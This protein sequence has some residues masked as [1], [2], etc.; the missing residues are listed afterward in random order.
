MSV[1]ATVTVPEKGCPPEIQKAA[2][3]G[4]QR[5]RIC[6]G[7]PEMAHNESIAAEASN[8]AADININDAYAPRYK[9]YGQ[10]IISSRE[11][12]ENFT[13]SGAAIEI[14][15]FDIFEKFASWKERPWFTGT[16]LGNRYFTQ[17]ELGDTKEFGVGCASFAREGK[18]YFYLVAFFKYPGQNLSIFGTPLV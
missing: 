17:R 4:F 11:K 18:N 1:T 7:L 5:R 9:P 12:P 10:F 2:V 13:D 14:K 16:L 15:N 3:E 6:R 8:Y